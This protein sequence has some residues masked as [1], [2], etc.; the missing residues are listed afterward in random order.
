MNSDASRTR[1]TPS[2]ETD[3]NPPR[4]GTAGLCWHT[5]KKG[6][7]V[8]GRVGGVLALFVIV[9]VF[10]LTAFG[11]GSGRGFGISSY[12][13]LG[14]GVFL[15]LGALG[16]V[17]GGALGLLRSLV[18]RGRLRG[19]DQ[20]AVIEARAVAARIAQAENR[21]RR[22]RLWPW[23][24]LVPLLVILP[25]AFYSGWEMG[26]NVDR[27]LAEAVAA[28]EEDDP[29]WR[30]DD[31]LAH[32]ELVPDAENSALILTQ[33]AAQLPENWPVTG[34]PKGGDP[35]DGPAT[36]EKAYQEL[37]EIPT[38]VRLSDGA[39]HLLRVELKKREPTVQLART[40]AKYRRGRFELKIG[41]A[42]IDTLLPHVQRTRSVAR[43]LAADSA[44]RAHD[45]DIDGA[46]ESCRAIVATGRSLS[47]EPLLISLLVR[48]AITNVALK[49]TSR[50]LG[51]GDPTDRRS[52]RCRSFCST[53]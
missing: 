32:R 33:V 8:L 7:R 5:A 50:V 9:P 44:M 6:A 41:R 17:F 20:A 30:L 14:I 37:N 19:A 51:Q 36:A 12:F 16:A 45:G 27:R 49:A 34:M 46:L 40:L 13:W 52:L 15:L 47:D 4:W 31:M 38:R 3:S 10:A 2:G 11:V 53:S 25:I 28:A 39:A 26:R 22:S 24:A 23:L 21:M 42:V 1:T 48:I 29:N 18:R 35:D 43:L